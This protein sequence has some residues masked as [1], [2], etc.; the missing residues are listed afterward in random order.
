[1]SDAIVSQSLRLAKLGATRSFPLQF[2]KIFA[3]KILACRKLRFVTA[4]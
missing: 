2:R 4:L 3:W 1:M